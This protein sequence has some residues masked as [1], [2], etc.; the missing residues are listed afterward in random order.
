MDNHQSMM[1]EHIVRVA[2]ISEIMDMSDQNRKATV[3]FQLKIICWEGG[4]PFQIRVYLR[5]VNFKWY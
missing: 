5:G 2:D 1:H 4:E 3:L